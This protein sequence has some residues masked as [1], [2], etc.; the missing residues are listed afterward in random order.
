MPTFQ[1]NDAVSLYYEIEGQGT[2]LLM[3]HGFMST[4]ATQFPALRAHLA[5]KYQVIAPDLRGY[6]QSTP[7]PRSYGVDFYRED[8]E[9]LIA[10]LEYL[11]LD[12]VIIVGFSDGGESAFWLPILAPDRIRAVVAWGAIG[13]FD[14]SIRASVISHLS[15]SWR[16][17][18]LDKLHGAEHISVMAERWVHALLGMID[19]G[20]D[21]TFGRAGEIRCPVL[22]MLGD[23]DE[24]NPVSKG[25]AMAQAIPQG[26]F[27]EF[28]NTGHHIHVE[29][30]K[31][32][33][34]TVD[35]FLKKV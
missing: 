32:F 15:M 31:R 17:P 5:K 19:R 2:P 10:L 16:T 7:K 14:N 9:D 13:Y 8:A 6:G 29:Q 4:G 11:K 3:I 33:Q 28:R 24:L 21:V 18:V 35:Q 20:G 30:P 26:Q 22:V 1:R 23:K 27:V 12:R 34:E 25:L